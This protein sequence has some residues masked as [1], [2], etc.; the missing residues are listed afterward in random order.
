MGMV[1][2]VMGECG[3]YDDHGEWSVAVYA[4]PGPAHAHA[5]MANEWAESAYMARPG[6]YDFDD[7]PCPYDP[8][9][10]ADIYPTKYRVV[11]VPMR[12]R[13]P[14]EVPFSKGPQQ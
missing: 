6:R 14:G 3:T 8:R 11:E 4:N 9:Y 1:Y 5:A 12:G 2:L 13:A 10:E 7:P